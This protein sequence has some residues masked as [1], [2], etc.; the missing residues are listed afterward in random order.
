VVHKFN[1]D[2]QGPLTTPIFLILILVGVVAP[3]QIKAYEK[4]GFRNQGPVVQDIGN[5]LIMDNYGM[6]KII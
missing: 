5:G 2:R 3:V 4:L 6:E 1:L